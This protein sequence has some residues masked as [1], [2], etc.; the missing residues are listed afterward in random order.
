MASMAC[1]MFTSISSLLFVVILIFLSTL[2][3]A[4]TLTLAEK[5]TKNAPY[6]I[7]FLPYI[8]KFIKII[9]CESTGKSY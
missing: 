1:S 6:A 8:K 5:L 9:F 2:L 4:V 7:F 3:G